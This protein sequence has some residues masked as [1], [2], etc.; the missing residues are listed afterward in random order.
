MT[1]APTRDQ[2]QHHAPE[3]RV[4]LVVDWTAD[5]H[6]VVAEASRHPRA[7]AFGVLVPAWLHGLDW[8]GDPRASIPCAHRQLMAVQDLAT[9]A[10]LRIE[11]AQVGDP[12][13]ATAIYDAVQDWPAGEVLLFSRARHLAFGPL[14]LEHRA[15]RLTGLPVHRI[16]APARAPGPRRARWGHRRAGHCVPDVAAVA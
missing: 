2:R 6:L 4:L 1:N 8:V 11:A 5:A 16:A 9:A 15:Q 10:G 3:S 13:P 12:D 14:D 7:T